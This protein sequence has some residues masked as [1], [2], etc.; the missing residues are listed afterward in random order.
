MIELGDADLAELEASV[1]RAL[2][3]GDES[4]LTVLGYG[5]LSLVLGWPTDRPRV[6]A[7]RLPAFE[8]RDRAEAYGQVISDYLDAL[9]LRGI[10]PVDT[11]F[12]VAPT[13]GGGWSAYVVQPIL[14]AAWL[15]PNALAVADD[16]AGRALIASIVT[17]IV[18]A[19]DEEVGIDGQLSN[20]ADTPDG[21]RYFD[22]T[23]PFLRDDAGVSRL[24]L[25]LLTSPLPA[26][27]RPAVRRFV[28]PGVTTRYHRARDVL[29]D[30]AANLL[31]ER[32]RRWVDP[33]V[34][35]ANLH[36]DEPIDR[37]GIERY[38]R[39]DARLWEVML[40]LRRADRW[41]Q[42]SIRRRPYG[43][44]LPGRIER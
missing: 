12:A 10:H 35:E 3:S 8:E 39:S 27:L 17:A 40:R 28:A 22:V 2:R 11:G 33:T 44:L 15:A 1:Q 23:T 21:L 24:D 25:D 19:V 41:W 30:L 42:R 36:L 26:A 31:K 16:E 29:E 38:Y 7:K 5:E 37:Q 18:G 4:G 6:A 9:R 32:L 34:E 14:D 43:A 13:D 20:W